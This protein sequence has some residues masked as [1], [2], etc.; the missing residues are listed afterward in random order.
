VASWPGISISLYAVDGEDLMLLETQLWEGAL[1]A[2]EQTPSVVFE[3]IHEDL[4]AD[5]FL[6]RVDDD[7]S[8]SI[9]GRQDECDESNNAVAFT[10]WPC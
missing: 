8:G 1:G 9:K 5:G 6:V 3:F 10:E 2:G 7:G 4:G